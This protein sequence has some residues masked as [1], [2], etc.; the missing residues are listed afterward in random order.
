MPSRWVLADLLTKKIKL[1]CIRSSL[2]TL[3]LWNSKDLGSVSKC[4]AGTVSITKGSGSASMPQGWAS[5][6]IGWVSLLWGDHLRLHD[7][8]WVQQGG[9][10][11]NMYVAPG[12]SLHTVIPGWTLTVPEWASTRTGWAFMNEG[13]LF[14]WAWS[15]WNSVG[16]NN[17]LFGTQ[18]FYWPRSMLLVIT[19]CRLFASELG[20]CRV[21]MS[22]DRL[23]FTDWSEGATMRGKL[24]TPGSAGSSMD[25]D[26][27]GRNNVYH[28]LVLIL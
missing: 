14:F 2:G 8:Q 6:Y 13:C 25:R 12:V 18:E 22:I 4:K 10:M 9:F 28:A 24:G 23:M 5:L 15:Y 27:L 19:K 26:S 21:S 17:P 7:S 20:S 1:R 3:P 16:F 11:V